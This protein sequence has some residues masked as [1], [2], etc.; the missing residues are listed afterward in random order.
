MNAFKAFVALLAFTA[1]IIINGVW[2]SPS[3][4]TFIALIMSGS[5]GLMIGDIFMLKAMSILGASRM[6][7]IFGLQPFFL[8]LG[9]LMIF[10]QSFSALNFAGLLCMTCCLYTI[11][12]EH[13]K[14]SGIW[15]IDGL[16]FGI[17]AIILDAVGIMLTRYG[18]EKT[19]GIETLQVNTIR[20]FGAIV[21]FA[22]IFFLKE[23]ISFKPTW[24]KF[25]SSEKKRIVAGSLLGTFISLLFYLVAIERGKLSVVSSVGVTGPMFASL[26]E[27]LR[28]KRWPSL[29]TLFAF[30]FF[31]MG[32]SI[33]FHLS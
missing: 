12:L 24:K 25:S 30:I 10:H 3:S 1:T 28:H 6:L 31:V 2:V 32:F 14:K 8:G 18:F 33:F 29:Y 13:F 5:I 9:A 21:A 15:H 7:M 11:S 16:I 17:V 19:P 22:F 27:S 20:C 23:R 26:F 4:N